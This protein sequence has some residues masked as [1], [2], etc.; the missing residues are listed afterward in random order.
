MRLLN[1]EVPHGIYIEVESFKERTNKQGNNIIDIDA[2]IY[3]LRE[4]HKGIII[5]K[6]GGMLKRIASS[7]RIDLEKFF[8]TKINLKVWV[9]V[10]ENWQENDNLVKKIF[11]KED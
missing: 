4:S 1:D 8:D 11:G 9:K 7:A 2:T 3:C 5:G 10:K 6:G